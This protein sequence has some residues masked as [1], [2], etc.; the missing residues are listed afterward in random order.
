MTTKNKQ[1]LEY[2]QKR[3]IPAVITDSSSGR[4]ID[5][6]IKKIEKDNGRT[7][8]ASGKQREE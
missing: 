5:N 4:G 3:G 8:I 7:I 2:F 6:C 1:W